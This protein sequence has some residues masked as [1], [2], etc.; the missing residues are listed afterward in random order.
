MKKRLSVVMTIAEINHDIATDVESRGT[1]EPV[2]AAVDLQVGG[3]LEKVKSVELYEREDGKLG[4]GV[5]FKPD[6]G[7]TLSDLFK[8]E[9]CNV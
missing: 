6:N 1:L 8:T 2:L 9:G 7:L 5:N 3:K 4:I